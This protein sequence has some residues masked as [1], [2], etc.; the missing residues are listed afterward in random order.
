MYTQRVCN[1]YPKNERDTRDIPWTCILCRRIL[2]SATTESTLLVNDFQVWADSQ[3][4][5]AGHFSS[6]IMLFLLSTLISRQH[7]SRSW[8]VITHDR[9][10]AKT[11]KTKGTVYR[12]LSGQRKNQHRSDRSHFPLCLHFPTRTTIPS[13]GSSVFHPLLR[14]DY[15]EKCNVAKEG[16]HMVA[17]NPSTGVLF[18]RTHIFITKSG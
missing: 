15:E 13:S 7:S 17:F 5:V 4:T 14:S 2:Q 9:W 1:G 10:L 11:E 18:D 16:E 12:T 8:H 3:K 6:V